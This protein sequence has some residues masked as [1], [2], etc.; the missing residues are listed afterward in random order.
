MLVAVNGCSGVFHL[1]SPCIIDQVHDP[2]KELLQPAIKGTL[3]VLTAFLLLRHSRFLSPMMI[4]EG[5]YL[6]GEAG[7]RDNLACIHLQRW[8]HSGGRFPG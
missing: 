1:A 3:N 7:Q 5:S 6:D 8:R 2:E 4:S